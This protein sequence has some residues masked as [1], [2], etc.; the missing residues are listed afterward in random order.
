[1]ANTIR[2]GM[3]TRRPPPI[4]YHL[5]HA[6]DVLEQVDE[7]IAVWEELIG[8]A[9]RQ[10]CDIL[11]L[12][13]GCLGLGRWKDAHWDRLNEILPPAVDRMLARLGRAAAARHLY[14]VG[15][16]DTVEPDGA[17]HNT[18]FLLGRDGREVGRYHK[19]HLPLSEQLKKRGDGFPVFETPD[20]G[21]VG[22]LICYDMV[23]PEAARSLA[24]AGA[25]ILFHPTLGGAAIGGAENSRAAFRTRAV[26]NFVYIAVCWGGPGSMLVSPQ[27]EILAEGETE[28]GILTADLDPFAGREGGDAMNRQ[29]DMRAR[30]FRERVP[31]AYG[32]LTAPDPW[33]LRKVPAVDTGE[34]VA[35]IA[36]AARTVGED[37]FQEAERLAKTGACEAAVR[38][39]EALIARYPKTWIDRVARERMEKLKIQN[40]G[41]ETIDAAC[42]HP[43]C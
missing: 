40:S 26:E 5:E 38:A 28:N 30:L 29:A 36:H 35:R 4:D 13:E 41:E 1:M 39:F 23:F 37:E 8:E 12:N 6:K 20:L 16:E 7:S 10:G 21:G 3:A 14:V 22:M 43:E 24:L 18:A 11:G 31:A 27:G 42:R 32:M 19:V 25:D 33:V 15:C 9:G 17:I 34:E 2:I